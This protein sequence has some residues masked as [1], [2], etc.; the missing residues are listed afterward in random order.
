MTQED[1]Q[2]SKATMDKK[3]TPS[4]RGQLPG[5][6]WIEPAE[7]KLPGFEH[8]FGHYRMIQEE[9]HKSKATM[10]ENRPPV[11][12]GGYLAPSELNPLNPNYQV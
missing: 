6:F 5:A 1:P 4:Q 10:D 7:S 12:K 2:I 8:N 9:P 11:R 3:L